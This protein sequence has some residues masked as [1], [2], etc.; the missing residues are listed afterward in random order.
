MRKLLS[1][2]GRFLKFVGRIAAEPFRRPTRLKFIIHYI[3]KDKPLVLFGPERYEFVDDTNILSF[4]DFLPILYKHADAIIYHDAFACEN[5]LPEK[6]VLVEMLEQKF[7][8]LSGAW[9]LS[10]PSKYFD[11]PL[12]KKYII[13]GSEIST[14]SVTQGQLQTLSIVDDDGKSLDTLTYYSPPL[15]G[16]K[17]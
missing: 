11:G 3:P 16:S 9:I 8:I 6:L 4:D 15:E 12:R 2:I 1:G 5:I 14:V 17:P 10:R 13:F 7:S